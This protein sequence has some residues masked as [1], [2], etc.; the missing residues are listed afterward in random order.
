[1]PLYPFGF[2]LS[3]TRFA[4]RHLRVA[5]APDRGLTV[6]AEVTNVGP[7]A[8]EEVV[9]LYLRPAPG[10]KQRRI[11]PGQPMPRLELAGFRRLPL[12]PHERVTVSFTL[13]PEDLRLFNAQGEHTLQPGQ[14]QVFV[15]GGQ[16]DL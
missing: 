4:Y 1:E 16:P 9:E 13:L 7:R 3:Y 11:A 14:W 8:G 15:S 6:T 10:E 2:G 5:P 12:Q